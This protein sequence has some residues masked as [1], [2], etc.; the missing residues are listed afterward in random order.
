VC[1]KGSRSQTPAISEECCTRRY[2]PYEQDRNGGLQDYFA[3]RTSCCLE[4]DGEA[5]CA[6]LRFASPPTVMRTMPRML[7]ASFKSVAV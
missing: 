6:L 3:H 5:Y 1:H 4:A 2:V 7:F